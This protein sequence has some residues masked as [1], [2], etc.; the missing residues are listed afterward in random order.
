MY[1]KL[2][3]FISSEDGT[4]CQGGEMSD[5]TFMQKEAFFIDTGRERSISKIRGV[6]KKVWF[7]MNFLPCQK[8]KKK[9]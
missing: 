2:N 8:Q 5:I 4:L 3:T 9:T 7:I 1:E 6:E